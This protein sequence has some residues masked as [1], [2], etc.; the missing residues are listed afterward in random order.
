MAIRTD[1]N[2]EGWIKFF[3]KGVFQVSQ[4]ATETARAI[5]Q[6][7]EDHRQAIAD[8]MGGRAALGLRLLDALY[9]QPIIS[10]AF[11]EKR[12]ECA[13][14]TANKIID[15]LAGLELLRETTGG[16]RNRRF[17]YEPY[18]NLFDTLAMGQVETQS[19]IPNVEATDNSNE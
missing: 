6:M 12:L 11:A 2:W 8:N 17:R 3:L 18:L 9:E 7:R 1:G 15:Q 13:Y 19:E 14:V 5:L 10:A 16:Q 4:S